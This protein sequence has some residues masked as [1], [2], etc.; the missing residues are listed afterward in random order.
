MMDLSVLCKSSR[1]PSLSW[2]AAAVICTVQQKERLSV[3][4]LKEPDG[5]PMAIS[6]F[7]RAA[8]QISWPFSL[9]NMQI[10]WGSRRGGL[11]ISWAQPQPHWPV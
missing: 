5:S 2:F 3:R 11:I 8:L 7:V 6:M 1:A 9:L 4:N 10:V